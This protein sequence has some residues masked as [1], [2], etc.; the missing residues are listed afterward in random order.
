MSNHNANNGDILRKIIRQEVRR[1]ARH[2]TMHFQLNTSQ[3]NS[4]D[5]RV[6]GF[7]GSGQKFT[8]TGV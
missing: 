8:G 5:D 1:D 7:S 2:I 3:A 6:H 4:T